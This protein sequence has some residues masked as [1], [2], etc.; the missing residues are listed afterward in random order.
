MSSIVIHKF[1]AKLSSPSNSDPAPIE[2]RQK[3]SKTAAKP[4]LNHATSITSISLPSP[5][6]IDPIEDRAFCYFHA[7]F[8]IGHSR[9]FKY[10]ETIYQHMGKH[11]SISIRAVGLASLSKAVRSTELEILA[12]KAYASALHLINGILST[13][14]AT[15]DATLSTVMLLDQFEKIIPAPSRSAQAW[16]NHL[17]GASALMKLRGPMQFKTKSGLEM[18]IQ[19]SSHLLVSCMQHEIPLPK[20]YLA[21]RTYATNFLDTTDI[22]WRLSEVTV[23]YIAFQAAIKDGSLFEPQTIIA[24]TAAMDAEM[25]A[26]LASVPFGWDGQTVP[27]LYPS[28]L[29]Y[30]SH[31]DIY[32]DYRIVEALNMVRAGR[33]PLF[34]LIREQAEKTFEPLSIECEVMLQQAIDNQE[35]MVRVIC[36]CVPQQAGYLSLINND[37]ENTANFSPP[38]FPSPISSPSSST[39]SPSSNSTSTSSSQKSIKLSTSHTVSA[40]SLLWPLFVVANSPYSPPAAKEWIIRQ[41]HI[42]GGLL[43]LEK[44]LELVRMLESE[45]EKKKDVWKVSTGPQAVR[46]RKRKIWGGSVAALRAVYSRVSGYRRWK[47]NERL[48][49]YGNGEVTA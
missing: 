49:F 42:F 19:M 3:P 39:S 2:R 9:S 8:V 7:T 35:E 12:T 47:V 29:V 40:Y 32:I 41:L 18:F 37:D 36:A 26:L 44:A 20:D 28:D 45:D 21:L 23:K 5:N 43:G 22:S 11:L 10:L 30:E 33:F 13:S 48:V 31:Y 34:H 46:R 25:A 16:T 6:P 24:A 27:L 14:Q 1:K 17:N 4:T 15:D 38:S